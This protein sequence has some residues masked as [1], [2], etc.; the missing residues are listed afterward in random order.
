MRIDQEEITNWLT[1]LFTVAGCPSDEA[2][3]IS[4]HLV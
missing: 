1:A 2:A 3:L 4:T